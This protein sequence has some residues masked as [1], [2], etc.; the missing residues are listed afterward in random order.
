MN[1][2][3][4]AV[5]RAQLPVGEGALQALQVLRPQPVE[6][7]MTELGAPGR[8]WRS[9]DAELT[10]GCHRWAS[11]VSSGGAVLQDDSS[12]L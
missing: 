6:P 5:S 12:D 3:I 8:G 1:A 10:V 2:Q 7:V 9:G 11:K 4:D